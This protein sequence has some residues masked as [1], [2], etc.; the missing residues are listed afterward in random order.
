MRG[1]LTFDIETHE[2]GLLYTMEP[3]DFVRL[4]GYRWKGQRD[5]V[6]TTDLEEIR[7]Q[8]LEARWIIGHNINSFDLPAVFGIRSDTPVELAHQGRVFDT[9][10]HGAL[11]NP[12]PFLYTNRFG[13]LC[14][15]DKPEKATR[16]FGL[17]EQ[18]FQLGVAGKTDDLKEL[19]FEFGDPELPKKDRIRDGFG[20]IPIDDERYSAYLIG[21]V[22]ASE[23]VSKALIRLGPLDAY[24]L[25]EQEIEARK[26]VIVANGF[27]VF[28]DRAKARVEK[29]AARRAAIMEGLVRDYDFPT[30][31]LAPWDTDPGKR[32]IMSA[33]ADAGITPKTVDWPKTPVWAKRSEKLQEVDEKIGETDAQVRLWKAELEDELTPHRRAVRERWVAQGEEK[34]RELREEPLKPYFGLALGGDELIALTRGTTAEDIGGALAELKGQRSLAQLA[35]DSVHADGFVHPQITMLQKSGRSSVTDPGLTIWDATGPE[36]AYFGPDSQ[37]ELLLEIDY[38]NADARGVCAMSGDFAYAER[39]KPGA[40]GHLI[41]AWAAWGKDKVGTDKHDPV[42]ADYRQKAKPLGHGWSYGGG[43]KT[44]SRESGVPLEDAKAFCEGLAKAF[45]RLVAWQERARKFAREHGYVVNDWGRR[46]PVERDRIYTQAPALLGQSWTRE[47]MWDAILR[48]PMTVLRRVKVTIHDALVFSVPREDFD[49]WREALCR[50]M[51]TSFTPQ[52]GGLSIDV[53]VE[54]GPPGADWTEASHR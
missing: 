36:K 13:K 25:R 8:I 9:W 33:L 7:D 45:Y 22:V 37:D 41:N 47:V 4:I 29:Q 3:A 34:I 17:D 16:W 44:L 35:L 32:A 48:M 11:V 5:V 21:D 20:K 18:A 46:M 30:Q 40:D 39:F 49:R 54:A 50:L 19:A 24:A 15:V 27:R 2:A 28:Q 52:K 38:S 1:T 6:L 43:Y 14:K 12:A 53:P 31:G 42:T 10:T 23:N 26:A 51:A